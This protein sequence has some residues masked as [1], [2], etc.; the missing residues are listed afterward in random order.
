MQSQVGLR[1]HHYEL[2]M[3]VEVVEFQL[4][5]FTSLKMM[6]LKCCIWYVSKFGKLSRG[7]GT[8]K[9]QFSFQ[10]QRKAMPKNV[11]TTSQLHSSH[12]SKIMLKILQ[13]RLQQYVNWEFPDVHDGFR[14]GKEPES[15]LPTSVGSYKNKRIIE[16]C[17]LL[18]HWLC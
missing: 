9:G 4:S 5:Y 3:L 11:L 10:S 15:K 13:P 18:L 7:H 6:L 8:G 17:I 1:K 12:A 16:N 14:K 2:V